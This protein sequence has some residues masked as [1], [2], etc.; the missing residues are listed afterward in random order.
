MLLFWSRYDI[1]VLLFWSRY[2]ILVLLFWSCY[3][4]LM[5]LFRL[6]YDVYM[7]LFWP[8]CDVYI[9]VVILVM[10]QCIDAKVLL[11]RL[12]VLTGRLEAF[13]VLV[14]NTQHI[15]L[16]EDH[17]PVNGRHWSIYLAVNTGSNRGIYL[18]VVINVQDHV[19]P[20]L[21]C[22]GYSCYSEPHDS[23]LRV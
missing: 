10:L 3:D 22:S 21:E 8:R 16:L 13:H 4:I 18:I 19:I 5:L 12:R 17:P 9:D 20:H 15:K 23:S 2:D 11:F 1:L 7:F 14:D 6:S